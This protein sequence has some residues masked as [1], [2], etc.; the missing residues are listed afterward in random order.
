LPNW[1]MTKNP[2]E[3]VG[4]PNYH[5]DSRWFLTTLALL[6]LAVLT[7]QATGSPYSS[8][9]KGS[10]FGKFIERI[11]G[12]STAG[13]LLVLVSE[14]LSWAFDNTINRLLGW[15]TLWTWHMWYIFVPGWLALISVST[16][17]IWWQLPEKTR[18][19]SFQEE[20]RGLPSSALVQMIKDFE[21]EMIHLTDKSEVMTG[22]NRD[23]YYQCANQIKKAKAELHRREDAHGG[24]RDLIRSVG[25]KTN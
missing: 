25:Q 15:S 10:L 23:M 19:S 24:H 13:A 9:N 6:A 16:F 4:N 11:W 7:R 12:V 8:S 2:I 18:Q 1:A 21:F 17:V 20:F 5:F 14:F 3:L 22:E